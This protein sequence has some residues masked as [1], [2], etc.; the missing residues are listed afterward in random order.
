MTESEIFR[1]YFYIS[2]YKTGIA[3]TV[4]YRRSF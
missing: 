2:E 1:S 3:E 4:S